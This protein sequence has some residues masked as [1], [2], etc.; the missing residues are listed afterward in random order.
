MLAIPSNALVFTRVFLWNW[1]KRNENTPYPPSP[2]KHT[3]SHTRHWRRKKK[4]WGVECKYSIYIITLV[5]FIESG[6]PKKSSNPLRRLTWDWRLI[7]IELGSSGFIPSFEI[8]IYV[9][10]TINFIIWFSGNLC[11]QVSHQIITKW[12]KRWILPECSNNSV[13]IYN[14][15][16]WIMN[17]SPPIKF[18]HKIMLSTIIGPSA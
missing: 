12:L 3:H 18:C 13:F 7:K 4:A 11:Q 9:Y 17:S 2:L 5:L 8:G 15:G 6:V 10:S 1:N 16:A 14:V